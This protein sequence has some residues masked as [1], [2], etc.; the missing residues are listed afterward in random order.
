MSGMQ[1]RL[2]HPEVSKEIED[3][4]DAMSPT[5]SNKKSSGTVLGP[6]KLFSQILV[7]SCKTTTRS[8]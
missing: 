7:R 5:A 1:C 3:E 4:W 8:K 2:R 6:L